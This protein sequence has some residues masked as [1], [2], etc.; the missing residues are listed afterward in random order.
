MPAV[1]AS[2][3]EHSNRRLAC[4]GLAVRSARFCLQT[5]TRRVTYSFNKS[6]H[7]ILPL[8]SQSSYLFTDLSIAGAVAH[9]VAFDGL[10]SAEVWR[11][12]HGKSG[13]GPTPFA[14]GKASDDGT[15]VL[16]PLGVALAFPTM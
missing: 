2:M 10:A 7:F 13:I 6:L 5:R 9:V 8:I 14:K 11:V 12:E 4:H 1:R 3:P 15:L 16:P